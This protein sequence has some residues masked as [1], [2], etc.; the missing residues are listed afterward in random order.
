MPDPK[1]DVA[2]LLRAVRRFVAAEQAHADDE[3]STRDAADLAHAD[4]MSVFDVQAVDDAISAHTALLDQLEQSQRERDEARKHLNSEYHARKASE[5][6][7][8]ELTAEVEELRQTVARCSRY[9]DS[10]EHHKAEAT[11]LRGALEPF[12]AVLDADVG[13]D[14]ADDD[15]F[16]PMQSQYNRAP[17]LTVGHFRAARQ[18]LQEGE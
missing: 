8:N 16:Q 18:A 11:R 3:S 10:V 1:I 17:K 13:V 5:S 6:R 2:E 4:L 15:I 7:V 14:E 9:K 12:A